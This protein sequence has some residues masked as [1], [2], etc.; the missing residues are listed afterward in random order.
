MQFSELVGKEIVNISTGERLGVVGEYDL[1]L[2]E[3]TGEILALI[4]PPERSFFG[5]RKS[6][7]VLEVSWKNVKKVGSDM[8]IIDYDGMY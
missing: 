7:S 1:I 4:I 8:I 3:G 5:F 6:E 2:D